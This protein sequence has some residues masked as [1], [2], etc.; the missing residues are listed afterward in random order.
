MRPP[1]IIIAITGHLQ[2]RLGRLAGTSELRQRSHLAKLNWGG[3]FEGL[4]KNVL[5]AKTGL[6]AVVPT[7]ECGLYIAGL[8]GDVCK[9]ISP[10][11]SRR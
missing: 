5:L 10:H 8:V 11:Y 3:A 4:R 1:I 7:G 9:S 6:H 2:I